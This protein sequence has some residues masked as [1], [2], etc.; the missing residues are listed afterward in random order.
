MS[1]NQLWY[2][3]RNDWTFAWKKGLKQLLN[4]CEVTGGLLVGCE[5]IRHIQ[6]NLNDQHYY[7][8]FWNMFLY[9]EWSGC[10]SQRSFCQSICKPDLHFSWYLAPFFSL[11]TVKKL[12]QWCICK[13]LVCMCLYCVSELLLSS[14]GWSTEGI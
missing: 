4:V 5:K 11:L 6:Y 2:V 10:V 7:T 9:W 12:Q 3:S 13:W 1:E 14:D 8:L